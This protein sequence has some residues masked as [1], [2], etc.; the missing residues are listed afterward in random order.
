M[1]EKQIEKDMAETDSMASSLGQIKVEDFEAV[2]DGF[3]NLLS[4]KMGTSKADLRHVIRD[5]VFL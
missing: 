4:H 5:R 1:T 2:E 3:H